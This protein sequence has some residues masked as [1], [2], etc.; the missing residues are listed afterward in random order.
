M[1]QRFWLLSLVSWV[2]RGLDG[3]RRAVHL[4]LMLLVLGTLV[5]ASVETPPT[6]MNRSAVVVAPVGNLV[7]ELDG[8]AATRAWQELLGTSVR[9]TL[10]RDVIE[11]I[12]EAAQ[13]KRINA[14]VLQLGAM[15]AAG[16][17][18]L[19]DIADAID[20]F[21]GSGK[22]VVAIG[23]NYTQG[24]YYLAAHANDIYMHPEG[25]VFV[26]GFGAYRTYYRSA[27][28]KF[29]IDVNVFKVGEYK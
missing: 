12:D 10:T 16:L 8:D 24:Q 6:V 3:L 13:D 14:L 26:Q 4:L 18:S 5:V 29:L 27:L 17:A 19:R 21:K 9:Q 22:P 28:E 11:A 2:W 15:G 25:V 23:D 20:R 1:A 7:E